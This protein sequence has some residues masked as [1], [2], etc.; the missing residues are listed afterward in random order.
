MTLIEVR[1]QIVTHYLKNDTF[2][3]P[4]DLKKIKVGKN[5]DVHKEKIV[6]AVLQDLAKDDI[7]REIVDAATKNAVAY[8]ITVPFNQNGQQVDISPQTAEL[9]AEIVNQYN[10]SLENDQ[11]PT[12]KLNINEF[13]IQQLAL[14]TAQLLN[15]LDQDKNESS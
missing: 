1:N 5:Q 8:I 4:E 11:D 12:D 14:I 13:D 2:F 15:N 7:C 3:I 9:V 10:Q 6:V